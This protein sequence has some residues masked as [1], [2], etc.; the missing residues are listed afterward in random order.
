[1]VQAWCKQR[2]FVFPP[3]KAKKAYQAKAPR[4]FFSVLLS[5]DGRTDTRANREKERARTDGHTGTYVGI[6]LTD[7]ETEIKLNRS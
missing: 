7:R 4:L 6:S 5:W 2:G 3:N 1:M